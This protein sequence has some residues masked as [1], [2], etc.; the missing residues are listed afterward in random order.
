M[1]RF[2]RFAGAGVRLGKPHD[3]PRMPF[4]LRHAA[5]AGPHPTSKPR[6]E[7]RLAELPG[8]FFP[9]ANNVLAQSPV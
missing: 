3:R 4:E 8:L 5:T 2:L 1:L 7:L 9:A 6:A